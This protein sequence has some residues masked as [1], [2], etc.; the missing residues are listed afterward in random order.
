MGRNSQKA[1]SIASGF[2]RL[3]VPVVVGPHGTKYRRMLLG[4][5]DREKIGMFMMQEQ[6]KKCML[7]QRRNTSS[8][9]L[10]LRRKPW[11]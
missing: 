6:E 7:D 3:G 9:Q 10:K 2:W 5:A 8:M 4:R 1:A 11:L